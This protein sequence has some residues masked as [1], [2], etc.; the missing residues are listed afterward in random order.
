MGFQIS[1]IANNAPLFTL[2]A[3]G[4][5]VILLESAKSGKPNVSF[6]VSLAGFILS[7]LLAV[8]GLKTEDV[9]FGGMLMNGS[10]SNFFAIVFC[11]TGSLTILISKSYLERFGQFRSEFYI[12]VL[13][14]AM[15]MVL[16]ASANDLIIIFLGIEL[17]S[18]SL[19]VLAGFFRTQDRS[20][21][22]ALKYF[23]LGAFAT[24]FLLYGIALVYGSAGST[25]FSVIHNQAPALMKNQ[26]LPDSVV[27]AGLPDSVVQAGLPDSVVQAGLPDS[28]VQ[29]G[30]SGLPA[31]QAGLAGTIFL[32]GLGLVIVGLAFK[33]AAAPFHMW[34]PDVYDGAPT[35]ATG[36]MATAAKAAAFGAFVSIA[37]KMIGS[38]SGTISNLLAVIAAASM[39]LGNVIAI[40]QSNIKRMLAY[41]SIAHAG[42]M[43]S[44]IAAA[45]VEGQAGVMYY[46][47][48]YACM[49]LG[50]FAIVSILERDDA[51]NLSIDGYAG[52]SAK[53]PVI[54]AALA[55]FM[56]SL[57]GIPPLAGFFGKYYVFLAAVKADMTWLAIVGVLTSLISA[58]YYLRVVVVMY[59]KE[60]EAAVEGRIGMST[61]V[62]IAVC[63]Y[64][65]VQLGVYP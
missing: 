18:V 59:F 36:F 53:H 28:V 9:S 35:P 12:L 15:G 1:D 4:L 27:Q 25:N 47:A 3:T 48:A 49:T 58:Y 20:N 54:A 50:A 37:F 62:A 21:E 56:F 55:L 14:A 8:G 30:D 16:M 38:T 45:N 32:L 61:V 43:L 17:M 65:V 26:P 42:Y 46:V 34:A 31:G 60:G 29:A 52:L 7:G 39:I 13:F 24:G 10:Y 57:A 19:Y 40:S 33:V 63:A 41:S 64:L 23:L 11:L 5:V 6:I 2:V 51:A 44:G 22:S